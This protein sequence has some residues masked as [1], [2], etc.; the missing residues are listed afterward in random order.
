MARY[1][2]VAGLPDRAVTRDH[3]VLVQTSAGTGLVSL[4]DAVTAVGAV[5]SIIS[6][7]SPV[8]VEG[9][10]ISRPIKEKFGDVISVKDFGAVGDGTTDDTV[11]VQAAINAALSGAVKTVYFPA[12]TYF[13]GLSQAQF[14]VGVANLSFVGD[15]RY[16]S[17]LKWDHGT[18]TG[19]TTQRSMFKSLGSTYGGQA[20][21]SL[22]FSGLQF[23][24]MYNEGTIGGGCV[25]Q[26]EYFTNITVE[27]CRF[28]A[29]GDFA[30]ACEAIYE[31]RIVGN[32]FDTIV[33]DACRFRSSHNVFISKN[34]FVHAD[35]D[36][37]ALHQANY[38]TGLGRQR[39]VIII[40][41]NV[42]EDTTG[43]SCL[44]A[45]ETIITGNI[46]NRCK[47]GAIRAYRGPLEGVNPMYS[48]TIA[49]NQIF[50]TLYRPPFST[51]PAA[52]IAVQPHL[53]RSGTGDAT[54]IPGTSHLSTLSVPRP[55]TYM[56]N[57]DS[58]PA[59]AIPAGYMVNVHDNV[60]MRTL[61]A[62]AKYSDWGYGQ[63][64]TSVGFADPA[65]PDSGM[66][67]VSAMV[68]SLNIVGLNVHDNYIANCR[69]GISILDEPVSAALIRQRFQNNTFHDCWEYGITYFGTVA[70]KTV[71]A[72]IVGNDFVIDPYLVSP[73]RSG[74]GWTNGYSVSRGIYMAG[75]RG[76][77]IADN[78]FEHCYLPIGGANEAHARD[79]F[80]RGQFTSLAWHADNKG[81]GTVPSSGK[82]YIIQ[83]VTN[84]MTDQANYTGLATVRKAESAAIPTSGWYAV[85]DFVHCTDPATANVYGWSRL[86][87]GT[88]HVAGTDWKTIALT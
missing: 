2:S 67:P 81:V 5:T 52:A 76:M 80:V 15:G 7:A 60:I 40:T 64:M 13:F 69:R 9:G 17:I 36:S 74:L 30:M 87:T 27:D 14:N 20:K 28:Y 71:Y 54:L 23:Q 73:G 19:Y 65:V 24:G 49:D 41:D 45:R 79:N 35:D 38:I 3:K 88:A 8:A 39:R 22:S 82:G 1:T 46:F 58:N 10:T 85:G 11:A 84:D 26:L 66:T 62:A 6:D 12:G 72:R 61:P 50:N 25:F 33:R 16:A 78:S 29:I 63:C 32:E 51:L 4:E 68:F 42:F 70:N 59:H 55:W 75:A 31:V 18:D 21:G 57:D 37:V 77:F 86:T 43:I 47:V 48:I 56:E 34:R 53:P 83:N 44:M